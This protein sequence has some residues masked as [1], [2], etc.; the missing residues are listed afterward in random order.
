MNSTKA[1]RGAAMAVAASA[2]LALP[3]TSAWAGHARAFLQDGDNNPVGEVG[4]GFDSFPD[5]PGPAIGPFPDTDGLRFRS[6]LS[7][8][9]INAVT[10]RAGVFLNDIGGWVSPRG[11]A[12]ALVGTGDGLSIVR[13][14]DP[15]NPVFIGQVGTADPTAFSNLWGDT[16]VYTARNG[17]GDDDDDDGGGDSSTSYVYYTTEADG[18]GIDILELNQLDDMGP[19]PDPTF[20][21]PVSAVFDA[22]GYDSAHN[23]F[24]NQESGFAYV[25]GVNLAPDE[26]GET[27]CDG[28]PNH[29]SRFNTLILDLKPDPLN[30]VIAACLADRGEHDFY[31]VNYN[32]PDEDYQGHEIAFVFDGR[33]LDALARFGNRT[34]ATPGVPVGGGT[35]IWDVTDKD[36]IKFI[37]EPIVPPGL[38][39][40]HQGWTS[41]SKHEF[42][43][44]N[45][46]VD[47]PR[48][49]EPND[50]TGFF[51]TLWCN[52]DEPQNLA[53]NPS[54][55]VVNIRDL[56][57]PVFQERFF[58]DAP[59]DND[60]NFV[61]K[62]NKLY[63][64]VYNAGTRVLKMKKKNGALDL[65]EIARLDSEPRTI[66]PPFFNGQW[67]I[68]PFPDRNLIVA[69][70]IVNG[71]IIMSLGDDDDDDDDDDDIDVAS[72]DDDD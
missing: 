53:P 63:W 30:P 68:F 18:I 13:V 17:N 52:S 7:R 67:G 38:C 55:Y 46:E 16:A 58:L 14:T 70:D 11:E 1:L 4:P 26:N 41:S 34:D 57:N 71:L 22:G 2:M 48:D 24:I 64:A 50:G 51:R 65:K 29:P 72:A 32:G 35:E 25:A 8:E 45:D 47:E 3:V 12:Y 40:S 6:Q 9:E 60:H 69:S 61:R 62:G 37:G 5:F 56:D 36:D 54:L 66:T 49:A 23:I 44:I 33:D 20:Q 19:A 39:F 21:I 59:G 10:S 27:A 28:D 42:L 43:L 31:V 15:D